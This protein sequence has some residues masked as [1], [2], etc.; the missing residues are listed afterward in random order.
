M[1]RRFLL[2][3]LPKGVHAQNCVPSQAVAAEMLNV[4]PRTVQST[5]VVRDRAG[6]ELQRGVDQGK[7]AVNVA[8]KAASLPP[9]QQREIAERAEAVFSAIMCVIATLTSGMGL[10]AKATS[11]LT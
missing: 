6:P 2:A 9:K 4:S 5:A 1:C 8:A 10:I 3:T 11:D 7:I